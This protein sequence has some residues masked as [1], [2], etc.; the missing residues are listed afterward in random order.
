MSGRRFSRIEVS[1]TQHQVGHLGVLLVALG[2]LG[3][4]AISARFPPFPTGFWNWTRRA[5]STCSRTHPLEAER[6]A[7]SCQTELVPGLA[8]PGCC[9]C[10]FPPFPV[11][12]PVLVLL[13][14]S[15]H[16]RLDHHRLSSPT[17]SGFVTLFS[18]HLFSSLPLE[19]SSTTPPF[20]TVPMSTTEATFVPSTISNS[21]L[22]GATTQQLMTVR[23]G[24]T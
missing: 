8:G 24:E 7:R 14:S 4:D 10:T 5:H 17:T 15:S 9:N 19:A 22:V 16:R 18:L 23:G 3:Y 12:V 1:A 20:S 21:A 13:V 2:R 11:P 6:E